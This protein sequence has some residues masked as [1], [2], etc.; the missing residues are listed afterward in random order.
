[1]PTVGLAII[2]VAAAGLYMM[3]QKKAKEA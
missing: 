1:V 3:A 2:G